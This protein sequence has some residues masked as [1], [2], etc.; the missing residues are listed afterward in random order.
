MEIQMK[1]FTTQDFEFY[2]TPDAL[3][4]KMWESFK[5]RDVT[6]V[7]EPS[8][9]IGSI[10]N[11][12]PMW[13][14]RG[15]RDLTIDVCELDMSFHPALKAIKSVNIVGMDFLEFGDGAAYS[16]ILLNPPFSCGVSHVLK[17]WNIAWDAEIV[18]LLNAQSIRNPTKEGQ[19]LCNLIAQHGHVEFIQDAFV[20]ED[21]IRQ[22]GV[23]IAMIYLRKSAGLDSGFASELISGLTAEDHD[24][25]A[26][27]MSTGYQRTQDLALP[28]N[29]IE[30]AVIAFDMAAKAMR[31][32]VL[33]QAKAAYFEDRLGQTMAARM[34]QQNE[35]PKDTSSKWVREEIASRYTR[36]KDRSWAGILRSGQFTSKLS[37]KAQ[38][39]FESEF[40]EIKK[41]GFTVKNVYGFLL[42][43]LESQN[44]IQ[45]EMACDIFDEI[46]RY[47]PENASFYK[48]WKS[49]A[50]HRT[51]G[52]RIK[53]TRFILPG[54][55]TYFSNSISYEAE[56]R[57]QDFDRVFSMLNG[58]SSAEEFGLYDVFKTKFHE[59]KRGERVDSTYFQ[60]RYFGGVGTIHFYVKSREIID[61]LNKFVGQHRQWLPQPDENAPENFWKQYDMAEKL[62]KQV[63]DAVNEVA[64][65]GRYYDSPL[66]SIFSSHDP[67]KG[68]AV[69][70]DVLT[71]VLEKHGINVDF[72]LT[73]ESADEPQQQ[74]L[75]A[76]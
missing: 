73:H 75:L 16:H 23:E 10:L 49:N 29:E 64:R 67:E 76:A 53:T 7:L 1:T 63:K 71:S 24:K 61:R 72:A 58:K 51:C 15:H 42:G 70:D 3:A 36:L 47:S 25:E 55:N 21:V 50:A 22:T 74:L 14:D 68:Y 46:S 66:R 56:R 59:L 20:G 9:G 57:L 41:L 54:N 6:R 69:L 28:K 4:R 35:A 5:N 65:K 38:K 44:Q 32:A 18:A 60:V 43:I 31:E 12:M 11:A 37:S 39:R 45:L 26:E 8:A 2:P 52:M 13:V 34:A 62:D 19:F 33:A 30:N 17:A 48:G 40:S 27:S